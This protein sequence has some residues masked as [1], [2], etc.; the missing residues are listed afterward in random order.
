MCVK[1]V[2]DLQQVYFQDMV[3]DK[4]NRDDNLKSVEAENSEGGDFKQSP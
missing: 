2:V 4:R 1:Y 3:N